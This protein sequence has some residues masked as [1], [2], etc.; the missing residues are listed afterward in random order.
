M[1]KKLGVIKLFSCLSISL[2]LNFFI[3]GAA[4]AKSDPCKILTNEEVRL[5]DDKVAKSIWMPLGKDKTNEH[6]LH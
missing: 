5:L 2:I 4:K 3:T 1:N 6:Y